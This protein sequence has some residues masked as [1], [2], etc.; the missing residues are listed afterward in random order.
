MT[1]KKCSKCGKIIDIDNEVVVLMPY[2]HVVCPDCGEWIIV[3]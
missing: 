2:P 1:E 3:F